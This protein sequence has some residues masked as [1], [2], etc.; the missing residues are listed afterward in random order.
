MNKAF[1]KIRTGF[2]YGVGF[3]IAISLMAIV[4]N[5]LGL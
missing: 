2:F 1:Q 3:V 4:S 5:L